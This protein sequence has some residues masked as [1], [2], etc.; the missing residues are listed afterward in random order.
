MAWEYGFHNSVNGDRVYN[1]DQ[2]S[3]IFNGLITDGV[4][5]A[6]ANK[7]A[8]QPNSGMVIQIA[9]GRGW[10]NNRWINNTSPYLI[11]LEASD[12][13]LNRYAAICVRG[14][15][16]TSVRTTEPYVKYGEYA[17]TPVKP[18]MTRTDDVK[19]YCLA[20]VYIGAGVTEITAG[21][22]EDTRQDSDL[23]GWVTGLIDQITPDTLYTQ[24]TAQFNEWF[25][26]IQDDLDENTKTMLVAALPT[27]LTATLTADG[28][29]E[30]GDTYT[31]SVSVT[32]MNT[33]KSV[34]ISPNSATVSEYSSAGIKATDQEANS[35]TFTAT[36][37]P[38]T[39]ISV[40][41]LHMG[42]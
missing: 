17:T 25:S 36:T 20:Y 9:T 2:M 14:D 38:T 7:L 30:S 41:I 26:Q 1:A 42:K 19:E 32:G 5:E 10:F 3:G 28:W 23:C 11:T 16:S 39:D 8:V 34:V 6:V 27:S 21:D 22:I 40:D 37:L 12:V 4:Y 15:N 29:T 31:Q 13:T 24:F 35:I 18:T 33:T